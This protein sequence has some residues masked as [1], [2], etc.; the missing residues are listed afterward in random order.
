[1]ER[2]K[3]DLFKKVEAIEKDNVEIKKANVEMKKAI[4]IQSICMKNMEEMMKKIMINIK[5][6]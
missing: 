5:F 3:S 1:M 2:Q 4:D 6:V